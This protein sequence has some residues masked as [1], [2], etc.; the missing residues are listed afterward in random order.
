M[1]TQTINNEI[2]ETLENIYEFIK[3]NEKISGDFTE[4]T[5]TLGIYGASENKIREHA[6]TYIFERA[7]PDFEQN[8]IM[9]YNETKSTDLSKAME[10]AFT[11]IFEIKRVLKNGFETYNLINEK[12]YILNITTKMTDYRG[13]GTGQFIVARVFEF[14]GE[15]YIIEITSYLQSS[16]KEDAMRY[17]MAKIIQ[18]PY[19]VYEDNELK[20]KE[21][22]ENIKSMYD[23][24][25][26]A[27]GTDE[28]ITS[29][30]FAD[31]I[32]GQFNDYCENKTSINIKDK[33]TLPETLEYFEVNEL[34]TDYDNFV[35]KSLDGFSSHKKNY[36]TGI[37][38]D[39][40]YGLYVIPFYK[41]I[42]T[43]L[44]QNSL[45]NIKGAKECVEH[46]IKSPTIPPNILEKLNPK[47]TELANK[48]LNK[49]MTFDEMMREYKPEYLR[50]KIY[51]QTTILYNSKVFT[52]TL[53]IVTEKE[54][55]SDIDYSNVKR[56]D[57][58]PCGS[59]K[60]YKHCCM[61]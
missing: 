4:Y 59:G 37:I 55:H 46:F 57:P 12:S 40:N 53:G 44:E 32:I 48:V 39:K 11:S 5:K 50:H 6:L 35:E 23:K 1:Q 41:T 13:L 8:P 58:C 21:I 27:F 60:K 31:D 49:N 56:N 52:N 43:I 2:H 7:I 45:D 25:M 15:N 19:L 10:K 36:D 34:N 38:Y 30:Q 18:E 20:E 24:F 61:K 29:S 47:F 16:Q 26:E 3:N 33:I 54:E 22:Q 42:S 17:A 28:I 14:N 51:S 9:I